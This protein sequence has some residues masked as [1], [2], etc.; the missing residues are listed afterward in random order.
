MLSRAFD[1][2]RYL[3]RHGYNRMFKY[4]SYVTYTSFMH[5]FVGLSMAKAAL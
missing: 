4:S 5:E 3:K 2:H 1:L